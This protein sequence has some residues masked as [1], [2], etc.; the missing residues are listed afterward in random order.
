MQLMLVQNRYHIRV[1]LWGRCIIL[2]LNCFSGCL[3]I[4]EISMGCFFTTKAQLSQNSLIKP[5]IVFSRD[6]SFNKGLDRFTTPFI[7]VTASSRENLV[8]FL[9]LR[10]PFESGM[11]LF[12][13]RFSWNY[14]TTVQPFRILKF[15]N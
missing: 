8:R 9:A 13:C 1:E 11:L 4:I 5:T 3:N 15:L 14:N 2:F 10:D 7:H 12:K 6:F